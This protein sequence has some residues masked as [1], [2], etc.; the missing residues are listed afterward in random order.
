M[1]WKLSTVIEVGVPD[2][3]GPAKELPG[4]ETSTVVPSGKKLEYRIGIVTSD[5][6]GGISIGPVVIVGAFTADPPKSKSKLSAVISSPGA[7]TG[8]VKVVVPVKVALLNMPGIADAGMV[9]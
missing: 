4:P 5:T 6:R 3:T 7:S 9:P 2:I 1:I 8:P